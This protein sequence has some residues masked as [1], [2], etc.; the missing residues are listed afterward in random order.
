MSENGRKQIMLNFQ[1]MARWCWKALINS[2]DN[3]DMPISYGQRKLV[4][5]DWLVSCLHESMPGYSERLEVYVSQVLTE[6]SVLTGDD[7]L[8]V[9]A[10]VYLAALMCGR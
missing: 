10:R 7:P 6:R 2:F 5:C 4:G 9:S 3:E 8:K 1:G